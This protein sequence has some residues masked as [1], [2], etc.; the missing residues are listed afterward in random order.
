MHVQ[1]GSYIIVTVKEEVVEVHDE[2]VRSLVGIRE[3][4]WQQLCTRRFCV[5][6]VGRRGGGGGGDTGWIV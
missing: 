3:V 2:G 5:S 4:V 1:V 6:L